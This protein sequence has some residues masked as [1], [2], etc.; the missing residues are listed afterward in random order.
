MEKKKSTRARGGH[1][2]VGQHGASKKKSLRIFHT[3][4]VHLGLKFTRS[5]YELATQDALVAARINTLATMVDLANKNQ[6]DLFVIAGD[7][8]DTIRVTKK[9]VKAAAEVLRQCE[10]VV[11]TLPGNH[12]Y[13]NTSDDELWST[14]EEHLGEGHILL[15]SDDPCD[16]RR[17]DLNVVIYPGICRSKHSEANAIGWIKDAVE[18]DVGVVRI[19]VAHG[20]LDGLS[21]DFDGKY[22]PMTRA[23]LENSGMHAWLLGHTHIR[24]PD[25]E[26]GKGDRLFFPSVPEPDGFDCDHDGFA[27]IID[28]Q[29]NGNVSYE[30]IQTGT[31]RFQRIDVVLNSENDFDQLRKQFKKMRPAQDLVKLSLSGRVPGDLFDSLANL[32]NELADCVFHLEMKSES[33]LREID[34]TEIDKEFTEGSFPHQLLRQL[35]SESD[36][37]AVQIAYEL[38]EENK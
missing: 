31:F 24:F 23:E 3:S 4:D 30:S 28:V 29:D 27:W 16:L 25:K 17:L 12:D 2:A 19:G 15:Q 13:L 8:F 9:L 20:S 21:P 1:Q 35:A 38:I 34:A 37:L 33:M 6:C 32:E 22:F 36:A 10:G 14:F 18:I 5:T 11:V 7:L 26:S